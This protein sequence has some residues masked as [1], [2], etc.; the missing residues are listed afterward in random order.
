MQREKQLVV[1]LGSGGTIAGTARS[2]DDNI[3]YRSAQL[4]VS[5]LVAA[6]PALAEYAIEAE[7][8]AQIDSKDMS[9]AV[10][11]RLVQ[12]ATFQLNRVEVAGV[13]ITHGTDTMEE[14]AWMLHR[15]LAPT[16]P[17]VLTG[18][19]HPATSLLPDGPQNLLDAVRV[20]TSRQAQGV[21]VA[22]AGEVHGASDVQK[23]HSRRLTTFASPHTGPVARIEDGRLEFSRPC[24]V[25]VPMAGEVI[26]QDPALWP[27]VEILTS[28]A[29]A[30][31]AAVQ[32][33]VAAGVRGLVVAGTGNG[34]VHMALNAALLLAAEQGV[35]VRVASRCAEG[36]VMF[37]ERFSE[38]FS[39]GSEASNQ[40][41]SYGALNAAKSRIELMLEILAG[42]AS[43]DKP[44]TNV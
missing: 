43:C 15:V 18:A 28:H 17:V 8:V 30:T 27:W 31:G 35:Q 3:G 44:S 5:Q 24:P 25:G 36:G 11:Q 26:N 20:A 21:L 32:A 7:Q 9:P 33:L 10:W 42:L 41:R 19:M 22:L 12:R 13:V 6:V 40:W 38:R 16:K 2:S 4:S 37:S 23:M 14:T 1:V 29:G 34:S 39:A